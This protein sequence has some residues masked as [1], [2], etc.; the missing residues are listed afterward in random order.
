MKKLFILVLI[1]LS[2]FV[3]AQYFWTD[4][5]TKIKKVWNTTSVPL[6]INQ[7]STWIVAANYNWARSGSNM[8]N[9]NSG[10][11]GIGTTLPLQNF[12]VSGSAGVSTQMYLGKS[13]N[14]NGGLYFQNNSNGNYFAFAAGAFAGNAIF[15]LPT[16]APTAGQVLTTSALSGGNASLSWTSISATSWSL[17]GN[18]GTNPSTNFIGTIDNQPL[19]IRVKNSSVAKITGNNIQMQSGNYI[20]GTDSAASS[21][22]LNFA[23]TSPNSV[24]ISSDGRTLNKPFMWLDPGSYLVKIFGGNG[25]GQ[26][27]FFSVDQTSVI[28]NHTNKI[29]L[30][31]SNVG[32]GSNSPGK[33]LDVSGTVR[34]SGVTTLANLSG[35]GA[36]YVGVDNSGNLSFSSGTAG[37]SGPTG[38]TGATGPTGA[39][40][41]VTIATNQVAYATGSNT[42]GGSNTFVFTG[43]NVG[44]GSATPGAKLDVNGSMKLL[45]GSDATG[46]LY[47]NGGTGA[48][49]RIGIGSTGQ[50][51]VV[52]GGIPSWASQAGVANY[53]HNISTPTTGATVSLT[54]NQYNIIN[55][56]GA[57]LALTINLPSTPSNN[58]VVYIKFTQ[59]VT[60]VTYGNGTV[61]DG[62]T[63]PTA[64]GLTVLTYDS[65][66]TSWY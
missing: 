24:M 44:I 8:Y 21:I 31:G 33:T 35:S 25:S 17:L 18:A 63:A 27:G 20:S 57:L 23:G 15:V 4:P 51:L 61:V 52:S 62:I 55:P 36:G 6:G 42:L 32:I 50:H 66:T 59:N 5:F 54:N 45:L 60:T 64:G 37:P 22:N 56:A 47:Y 26:Q 48:V 34:V 9:R 43:I 3:Q 13:S 14:S 58:D 12:Y 53:I 46:D 30:T 28:I 7:D 11:V 29:V 40:G 19:V 10:N 16:V 49:T 65:G 41:S 2:S 1:T 38:L 39:A